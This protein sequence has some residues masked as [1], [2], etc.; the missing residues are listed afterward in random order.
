MRQIS[1]M[2]RTILS[3]YLKIYLD[4]DSKIILLN[5]QNYYVGC[6]SIMSN[7]TQ[8]FD[9]PAISL[10]V[11]HNYF[12]RLTKLFS[13]LY[14]PKFLSTLVKSFRTFKYYPVLYEIV[15]A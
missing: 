8:N 15:K 7:A 11:L 5:C 1:Y 3:R 10:S 13:Y 2:E 14:L 6:S 12:N 9:I 4:T